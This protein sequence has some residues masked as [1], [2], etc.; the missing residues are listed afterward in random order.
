[1]WLMLSMVCGVALARPAHAQWGNPSQSV[2]GPMWACSPSQ[3]GSILTTNIFKGQRCRMTHFSPSLGLLFFTAQDQSGA[4]SKKCYVPGYL[5]APVVQVNNNVQVGVAIGGSVMLQSTQSNVYVAPQ[6][7]YFAAPAGAAAPIIQK[8]NNVQ[9]AWAIG[10]TVL[11]QSDQANVAVPS[12]ASG[13]IIQVNNNVQVGVAI[14]G[15]VI[16]SSNQ[17]NIAS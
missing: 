1:M 8:N 13:P 17:T 9:Q 6:T 5:V 2:R 3:Y 16:L 4:P 11:M 7:W 15:D 12:T 10:G 14:G